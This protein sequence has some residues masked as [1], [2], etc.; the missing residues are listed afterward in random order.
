MCNER[1]SAA[2]FTGGFSEP[3]NCL[4][5]MENRQKRLNECYMYAIMYQPLCILFSVWNLNTLSAKIFGV[6]NFRTKICPKIYL[7][8]M[9]YCP[10]ICHAENFLTDMRVCSVNSMTTRGTETR[11]MKANLNPRMKDYRKHSKF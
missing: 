9:W 6:T 5:R 7:Y 10:K 4:M 2:C 3:F 1:G 11:N 8:E